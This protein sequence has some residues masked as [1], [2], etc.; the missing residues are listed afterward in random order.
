MMDMILR[1]VRTV[2]EEIA[3]KSANDA[4]KVTPRSVSTIA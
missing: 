2:T 1:G 4:V 3:T